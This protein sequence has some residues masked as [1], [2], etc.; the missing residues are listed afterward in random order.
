M[1]CYF[2]ACILFVILVYILYTRKKTVEG[3]INR[4]NELGLVTFSNK[5]QQMINSI[6]LKQKELNVLLKMKSTDEVKEQRSDLFDEINEMIDNWIDENDDSFKDPVI[7]KQ[8]KL[9]ITIFKNIKNK[10][11]ELSII[12][13]NKDLTNEKIKEEKEE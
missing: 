11:N 13:Q 3:N 5:S 12:Y 2:E 6:T 1:E 7:E 4:K 10:N 8:R 9:M